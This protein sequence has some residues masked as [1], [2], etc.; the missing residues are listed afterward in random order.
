MHPW[1]AG[2]GMGG[3][4][5]GVMGML[6]VIQ[7]DFARLEVRGPGRGQILSKSVLLTLYRV[8]KTLFDTM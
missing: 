8:Y 6:E 7:S 4:N 1:V 2:L 3:E 5:G